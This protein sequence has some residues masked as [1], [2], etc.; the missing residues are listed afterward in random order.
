MIFCRTGSKLMKWG[1]RRRMINRKM[2]RVPRI[3][4][5]QRKSFFVLLIENLLPSAIFP[6][7]RLAMLQGSSKKHS[8]PRWQAQNFARPGNHLN[9]FASA[10]C[11]IDLRIYQHPAF[12]KARAAIFFAGGDGGRPDRFGYFAGHGS[13]SASARFGQGVSAKQ[14]RAS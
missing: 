3:P 8:A 13:R 11:R 6:L 7:A 1:K 9:N 5:A 10:F 14:A 4:V 12:G 2:R